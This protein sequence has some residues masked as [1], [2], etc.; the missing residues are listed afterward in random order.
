VKTPSHRPRRAVT[1]AYL[2]VLLALPFCGFGLLIAVPAA[3]H[4]SGYVIVAAAVPIGVFLASIARLAGKPLLCASCGDVIPVGEHHHTIGEE[5]VRVGL[6]GVTTVID[7]RHLEHRHMSC[8]PPAA[9][10]RRVA[11]GRDQ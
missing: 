9:V 4:Y 5:T 1:G 2:R 3:G 8:V 6:L 11:P 10:V 7:S